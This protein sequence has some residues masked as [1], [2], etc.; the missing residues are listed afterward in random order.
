MTVQS[1]ESSH[2]LLSCTDGVAASTTDIFLLVGRVLIGWLFLATG[3]SS[4]TSQASK[5]T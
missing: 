3:A 5:A 2:P 4:R 1:S